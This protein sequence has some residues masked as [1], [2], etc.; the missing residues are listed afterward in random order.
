M[1][2]DVWPQAG[3]ALGGGHYSTVTQI[4]KDNVG[5]L[6]VAW[7]HRSGD[8]HEGGNTIDGVVSGEPFQTSLQVTPVLFEDTLYYCTPYNRV[9]ALDPNTGVERWSYDPEVAEENR[10]G[11]CRGWRPGRAAWFQL[12]VCA[13]RVSLRVRLMA[14]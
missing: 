9:F 1:L 11:P 5:G 6:E 14:A 13:K 8:Y 3:G 12:A 2:D 10:G 7:T 4:T